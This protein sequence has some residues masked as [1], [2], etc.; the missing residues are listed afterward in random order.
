MKV[1]NVGTATTGPVIQTTARTNLGFLFID[2]VDQHP[3]QTVQEPNW[4][5]FLNRLKK[6]FGRES[7]SMLPT[8]SNLPLA[9]LG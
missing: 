1:F 2:M 9:D 8:R 6:L 5:G 3:P 4:K 7:Q